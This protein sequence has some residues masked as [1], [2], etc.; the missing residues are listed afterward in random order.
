MDAGGRIIETEAD[1]ADGIAWLSRTE[2]RFADVAAQTGLPPLRRRPPGFATLLQVIC[3]QQLSVA[4]A[5]ACWGRLQEV[6]ASDPACLMAMADEDL[7]AAG[8]SRPKIRYARALAEADLDY[9]ALAVMPEAEAV[10]ALTAVKGIGL[11]SAEIYLLSAIGRADI[12]PAGDLALQE[13]AKVAFALPERP[14]EPAFRAMAEAWSPWRAVAAR[15]LWAYYRVVK[16]R[17]G[18]Q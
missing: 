3:G 8:L 6:G 12:M 7:K 4:S 13:A 1:L 14:P 10:A 5:A 16:D 17:E 11:W 15:L 18:L 9:G 2:P